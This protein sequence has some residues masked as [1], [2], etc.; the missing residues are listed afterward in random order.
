MSAINEWI[1]VCRVKAIIETVCDKYIQRAKYAFY[2]GDNE[3]YNITMHQIG[4][5]YA[6]AKD[7]N[8]QDEMINFQNFF[9][10]DALIVIG[11]IPIEDISVE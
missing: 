1:E 11:E 10:Q 8:F 6:L 2:N 5:L 4:T 9:N 3:K 7:F